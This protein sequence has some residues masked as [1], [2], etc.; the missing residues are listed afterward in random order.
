MTSLPE[1][2]AP[3]KDGKWQTGL[4]VHN[5][6]TGE[7]TEFMPLE[8]RRVRW[9]ACGPTVYD[10]S[11]MGHART[12]VIFD[13]IYR[14]MTDYL[15]YDVQFVMNIT[16]I[17]DKII[18]RAQEQG[19]DFVAVA[20][21]WEDR[22]WHDMTRLGCRLPDLITR[23]SEFVDEVISFIEGIIANGFAYESE[24]SVYFDTAA[25]R[26]SPKHTYGRMEPSA[27]SEEARVLEGE[28]DLGIV[29]QKRT[30][31]DFALWKKS[32]PGEP[33]WKSPWGDGRPGWHIECSA[34]ASHA[35]GFP[36][37]IHSGGCDLRFPHHDNELAQSEAKYD[38]PQWVNYF[39]HSGHLNIYGEKM[40]KTLKNFVTI[41]EALKEVSPRVIRLAILQ[42][43]WNAPMNYAPDGSTLHEAINVDKAFTNFFATVR[44]M[45]RKE[46]LDAPQRWN[47]TSSDLDAHLNQ[48]IVTMHGAILDSFDTPVVVTSLQSIVNRVQRAL[49]NSEERAAW[50]LVQ[51]AARTA[52]RMLKHLGVASGSEDDMNYSEPGVAS[53][54]Q[55]VAPVMDALAAFRAQIRKGVGKGLSD[56]AQLCPADKPA[57]ESCLVNL[58]GHCDTLRDETLVDLGIQLNDSGAVDALWQRKEKGAILRERQEKQDKE[59]AKRK[60]KEQQQAAQVEKEARLRISPV[61]FFKVTRPGDFGSFD[62]AGMPLTT[63]DGENVSKSQSAKLRKALDQH[64]KAFTDF[65]AKRTSAP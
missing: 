60:A 30:A 61:D 15:G 27:V 47:A 14:L 52:F 33:S 38:K 2:K 51:K 22:F 3:S 32:K 43:R 20:R 18:K 9:Y 19:K 54:G 56:A 48:C 1:W 29:T 7:K 57:V 37:D 13:A 34:M 59:E 35:L 17:D 8:G 55:G 23:V 63:A 41:D 42:N 16:D 62:E 65:Q 45:K 6:M 26:A 10:A 36:L 64:T 11:H 28:G 31:I 44:A 58:M 25:F 46:C 24:G 49:L 50:P 40:A 4:R 39:L 12:Y 21:Y 53:D 5:S